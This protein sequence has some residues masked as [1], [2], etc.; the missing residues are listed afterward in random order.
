M[1]DLTEL[2]KSFHIKP[3]QDSLIYYDLAFTH[4]SFNADKKT[5]HHDY[6]R[7]EFLGDSIIGLTVATLAF[8]ER[9]ELN[10]GDLTKLRSS[11]VKTSGLAGYAKKYNLL[12]YVQFGNSYIENERNIDGLLEDVFE[13][14]MGA[15]YLDQ[16]FSFTFKLIKKIFNNEIIH[17]SNKEITDYKSKLQEDMQAEH[18]Q[19]VSYKLIS[20]TG[21]AHAKIFKVA[22]YFDNQLLATGEGNS[23]KEAEQAAAKAAFRK[24]A[25]K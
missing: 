22:V 5:H 21:P 25:S 4:S 18:R 13:A 11:L 15:I 7:I 24:A 20:S 1:H 23:K 3:K 19:S 14:F 6:E 9:K 17:Y 2:F 10:Q 16:G 12:K 8:N